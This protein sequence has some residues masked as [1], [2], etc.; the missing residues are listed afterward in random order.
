MLVV[1]NKVCY[2]LSYFGGKM[3]GFLKSIF[4]GSVVL[5]SSLATACKI[6]DFTWDDNLAEHVVI[7]YVTIGT[8]PVES[9]NPATKEML[10]E[11]NKI[12]TEKLNAELKITYIPEEDTQ[13]NYDIEVKK[14]D[15]SV[16]LIGTATD[17]LDAWSYVKN[18]SFSKI[19]KDCLEEYAPLTYAQVTND[20]WLKCAYKGDIYLI[21]ENKYKQWVNHGFMYRMDWAKEAGLENGVHSW[22]DLTEYFKYVKES[23]PDVIPWDSNGD[24][25]SYHGEGYIQSKTD[26]IILEGINVSRMFGVSR[27]NLEK[28]YSPFYEGDELIEYAKLM[29]EWNNMGVWKESVLHNIS[30]NRKNRDEFY[31]GLSSVEQHH[32]Q[33]WYTQVRPEMN[34]RQPGSDVEFFW[35]GEESKN[36]TPMSITHGA[37]AVSNYSLNKGRA[38]AVYDLLRN[39]PECYRLFNYGILGADYEIDENNHRVLP[40]NYDSNRRIVTNFWWGRND[41]LEIRDALS[42]WD[43]FNE[44]STL[45][46]SLQFE[47]DYSQL[48]WD[49]TKI[50]VQ[51]KNIDAVWREFMGDICYGQDEDPEALVAEFR[52]KLKLA[53]IE[54]VLVEL[55]HQ[56]NFFNA[57]R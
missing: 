51:L 13:K 8:K 5:A 4:F 1:S 42:D 25:S 56:V 18:G 31:A 37:M 39:D 10:A 33:T 50:E 57:S 12:L 32:C 3:K 44:V 29:R 36:I 27:K 55:Q 15:G 47:T 49:F 24:I 48:I 17:W 9:S 20:D 41:D 6:R 11:L 52:S 7:N 21:P 34:K 23:K 45:Y 22:E 46:E 40:A 16:D 53:G 19:P 43:K 38:L 2:N 30:D 28:V 14:Q 54:D 35:F 26:F